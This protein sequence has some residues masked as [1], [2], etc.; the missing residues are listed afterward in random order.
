MVDPAD[1]NHQW[2]ELSLVVGGFGYFKALSAACRLA[3]FDFLSER[4]EQTVAELSSSTGVPDR[5]MR[6]L[7]QTLLSLRLVERLSNER[8]RNTEVAQSALVCDSPQNILAVIE[9]FDR[10]LYPGMSRLES[11]LREGRNLGIAALPGDGATIY[12]RLRADPELE[13]AAGHLR[14]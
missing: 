3:V 9:G 8:F 14:A 7:L 10:I 11:S 6:L 2:R 12:E 1:L 5:S 4:P 13:A